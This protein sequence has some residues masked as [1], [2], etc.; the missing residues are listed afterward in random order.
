M[1]RLVFL[2]AMVFAAVPPLHAPRAANSLQMQQTWAILDQCRKESS[3]KF[4][5][6][7]KEGQQQRDRYVKACT[8]RRGNGQAAPLGQD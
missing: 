6:Q 7:T 5:D 2:T 4:P 1:R 8:A 3:Q